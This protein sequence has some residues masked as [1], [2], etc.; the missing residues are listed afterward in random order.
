MSAK[1]YLKN[2]F[3]C[4]LLAFYLVSSTPRIIWGEDSITQKYEE[5]QEDND[6]IRVEAHYLKVEKDLGVNTTVSVVGLIDTITGS[7]PTGEPIQEDDL[8]QVPL[9][10]LEDRRKS[11]VVN[12]E[13]K[14]GD[15]AFTFELSY[16]DE[17]DY[18]SQGGT[19]S[20][21][22]ELNKNNTTLQ[23]GYSLL[24]DELTAP[25]LRDPEVKTSHDLFFGIS[26][27]V[28]PSTVVR[29]NIA[30]GQE[31][32]Y[33]ADPYKIVLKSVEI[34]PDFFLPI[35]FPENRPRSRDKWIFFTEAMRDFDTLKGSMQTSYRF[36]SDDAG[37]DSH[38]FTVEWFQKLSDKVILRPIYRYYKQS[39]SDFYY[40]DLDQTS[41]IPN[42][43]LRGTGPFYSS[44][45]RL[46]KMETQTYGAKL[47][48]F[49]MDDLEF[50][51]KFNRYEMK[52]L[53]GITHHS[54]YSNAD[55]FTVGGRWWF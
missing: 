17:S 36:F 41:I 23:L 50:N 15:N 22:R 54:A 24:D 46:S 52:G 2:Q 34:L 29:A 1:S 14:R 16:S 42:R 8:N 12:L 13:H 44:D 43:S 5:Y 18:V 37:I 47:I 49:V 9:E 40:Y 31:N 28:D 4:L 19:L 39:A 6:R 32:G 27:V 25:T 30:Y 45:H 10:H 33:L 7:T 26:Q 38:T 51:V 3:H 21:K 53:D 20:Y 11:A 48:W 35:R 55:I